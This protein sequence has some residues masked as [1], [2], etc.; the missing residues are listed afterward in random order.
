VF[1]GHDLILGDRRIAPV[2]RNRTPDECRRRIEAFCMPAHDPTVM[3]RVSMVRTLRYEEALRIG[4]GFDYILQA[5]ETHA[6]EVLGECLYSYRVH[7]ASSTRRDPG[8]RLR[9]LRELR[10]RAEIR[11]GRQP[12]LVPELQPRRTWRNRDYDNNLAAHFMDS[13][14]CLRQRGRRLQ[15]LQTALRCSR[16]HPLDPHYHKA[17]LLA[18]LPL[19]WVSKLRRR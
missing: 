6:M 3:F 14:V 17:V 2:F 11:R 5:G 7:D 16:I 15:A 18:I 9:D 19:R 8:K 12:S 4:Q 10:R 1:C 13:V